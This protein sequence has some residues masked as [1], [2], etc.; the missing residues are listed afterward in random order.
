MA[1]PRLDAVL[2]HDDPVM[3]LRLEPNDG[4]RI[5]RALE[6]FHAT[7]KSLDFIGSNNPARRCSMWSSARG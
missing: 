5:V 2:M 7:G 4:Q 6:V 3:A 1:L